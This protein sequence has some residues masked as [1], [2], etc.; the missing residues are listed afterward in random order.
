[1]GET[2]LLWQ[3]RLMPKLP[4]LKKLWPVDVFLFASPVY[5]PDEAERKQVFRKIC[6]ELDW[7][8]G[9]FRECLVHHLVDSEESAREAALAGSDGRAAVHVALSGGVQPW[10]LQVAEGRAHLGLLNGYLPG[11]F[12]DEITHAVMHRNAHP[13]STDFHAHMLT[14]VNPSRWIDSREGF[15]AWLSGWQGAQRLKHARILK[16]GETEPWVIN[17]CRSPER[18][19]EKWGTRVIPVDRDDLYAAIQ[20]SNPDRG[21]ELATDWVEKSGSMT[22][23]VTEDVRKACQ[24]T[25]GME[26][27]LEQ[28]EADALSMACFAMIGDIDTTSCLALSTLNDSASAIGACEGDLDAAVTLFLLRGLGADFVWIGNPILQPGRFLEL[29][30]CTAPRCACGDL[31]PYK[32]MRHHESG[33]GVAP[34]VALPGD[35]E[36]T[37]ARIGANLNRLAVHPGRTERIGKMPTCHTQIRVDVGDTRRVVDHLLGT[38]LVMSYGEW[39]ASLREA[40]RFLDL[41]VVPGD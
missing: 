31:L 37:L 25:A 17:S 40:A 14:E 29:A 18:F 9:A 32:L 33:R 26:A 34:E 22:G 7:V 23:I 11:F 2:L 6:D 39:G 4:T 28:H 12:S 10:M 3:N 15:A 19:E 21:L 20:S 13:A 27:L 8:A 35:R 36:V 16:I 24:V 5:W 1:M 30:H 38:H 41:E